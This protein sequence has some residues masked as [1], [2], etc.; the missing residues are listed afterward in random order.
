MRCFKGMMM[1]TLL[2]LLCAVVC[3]VKSNEI[4]VNSSG[5]KVAV[6]LSSDGDTIILPR[7]V[8]TGQNNLN[9][10]VSLKSITIQSEDLDP[11][12]TIIDCNSKN[13]Y[14]KARAFI[15]IDNT[16][17]NPSNLIS[18]NFTLRGITIKNCEN[19][20][21]GG[22]IYF[23]INIPN[24]PSFIPTPSIDTR[25]TTF[26]IDNCIFDN[27]NVNTD[28]GLGGGAVFAGLVNQKTMTS[29][30]ELSRSI[31]KQF[32]EHSQ[33]SQFEFQENSQFES[34]QQ[35]QQ[36]DQPI[37]ILYV[38][39]MNS[40]FVNNTCMGNGGAFSVSTALFYVSNCSMNENYANTG[41]AGAISTNAYFDIRN[42]HFEQ[43]SA[44]SA[45]GVILASDFAEGQVTQCQF[46]SNFVVNGGG[47]VFFL[48]QAFLIAT[49]SDFSFNIVVGTGGV[50]YITEAFSGTRLISCNLRNNT[51][52]NHGG[53]VFVQGGAGLNSFNSIL[54]GNTAGSGGAISCLASS[55]IGMTNSELNNNW[56]KQG[57]AIF[58]MYSCKSTFDQSKIQQNVAQVTGGSFFCSSSTINITR[59]IVSDNMSPDQN[60]GYL[61]SLNIT[62]GNGV[63]CSEVPIGTRCTVVGDPGWNTFCLSN[64]IT[65][66]DTVKNETLKL[67]VLVIGV[68]VGSLLLGVLVG[69]LL[70]RR[71]K[72]KQ[73]TILSLD[74]V[75]SS[76][77]SL[78]LENNAMDNENESDSP[79][80]NVVDGSTE[81]DHNERWV[82]NETN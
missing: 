20:N 79:Q 2:L 22:A 71:Q 32:L 26:V 57:G 6:D 45:G 51:A 77:E 25:N 47:G 68:F 43:N 58:T 14:T 24:Y 61:S 37:P 13:T 48:Y 27:N 35:T 74:S 76:E 31:S 49:S 81:I 21:E 40:I 29:K 7:G 28:N 53:A 56:S 17:V 39:F 64:G 62:L 69:A 1:R 3:L 72:A 9:V 42:S 59:T 82:E 78:D 23:G 19:E 70:V 33:I 30:V 41:G 44:Y 12:G 4:I 66:D 50:L 10:D 8:Y 73:H 36:S 34:K 38:Y 80:S 52:F 46:T 75:V 5:L 67:V 15:W 54:D 60:N 63:Y 11:Y 18:R 55:K 65:H 16:Y